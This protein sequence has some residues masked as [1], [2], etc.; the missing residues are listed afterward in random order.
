MS[1][2]HRTAFARFRCGVYSLLIETA[3]YERKNVHKRTC[4]SYNSLVEDEFHVIVLYI[5]I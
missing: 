2:K 1:L 3:M 5:E 4:F